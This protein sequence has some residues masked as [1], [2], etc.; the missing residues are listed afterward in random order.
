MTL[1]KGVEEAIKSRIPEIEQVMMTNDV[2]PGFMPL[3][4]RVDK[5]ELI[6]SGWKQGPN[7]DDVED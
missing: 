3:I 6:D 2:S 7:L 5:D 4:S 1:K